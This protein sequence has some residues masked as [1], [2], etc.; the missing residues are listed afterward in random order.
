MSVLPYAPAGMS[1]FEDALLKTGWG[2]Y[3]KFLVGFT[4]SCFFANA[5]A[6]M[7]LHIYMPLITCDIAM[8]E[9]TILNIHVSTSLGMAF[10][11][12]FLSSTSDV[13][14]RKG[15]ISLSLMFVFIGALAS[16]FTFGIFTIMFAQF[17]LGTGLVANW[18]VTKIL[19]IEVLPI[20]KRS[21]SI[22]FLDIFA[23]LGTIVAVLISFSCMPVVIE[24]RG[25]SARLV[26]WRLL[27]GFTG[28]ISVFTACVSAL[29][30]ES[31]RYLVYENRPAQAIFILSEIFAINKSKL[32]TGYPLTDVDL[33]GKI[34]NFGINTERDIPH[35]FSSRRCFIILKR[36]RKSMIILMTKQFCG[37]IMLCSILKLATCLGLFLLMMMLTKTM[38]YNDACLLDGMN[39]LHFEHPLYRD[40]KDYNVDI[41]MYRD[42][43][44]L[45]SVSVVGHVMTIVFVS[46]VDRKYL[47]FS[48]LFLSGLLMLSLSFIGSSYT[49]RFVI[50]CVAVIG[51]ATADSALN[52]LTIEM[53]PTAIRGTSL[54]EI[55]I[56]KHVA[57]T[58]LERFMVV[59]CK[60]IF[61]VFAALLEVGAIFSLALPKLKKRALYD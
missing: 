15:I 4:A 27:Y 30:L 47:V 57:V 58:L 34:A 25:S 20:Y 35:T 13:V 26:S 12:F 17:A 6:F 29:I 38:V 41:S 10:G 53:F 39:W 43:L 9:N 56:L 23:R 60:W 16:S 40:C 32:A 37:S 51:F 61:V 45:A 21:K 31:P 2:L 7:S 50:S 42:F 48:G 28:F 55:E 14:G 33:Q 11:G 18:N 1:N 3:S 59:Q 49:A 46:Y 22:I 19:L 8:S 52:V 54:G 24:Y 44:V 5:M 36:V